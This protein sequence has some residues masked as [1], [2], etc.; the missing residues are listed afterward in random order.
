MGQAV[1]LQCKCCGHEFHQRRGGGFNHVVWWCRTCDAERL[2]PRH[3]PE[4]APA[5]TTPEAM[6]SYLAEGAAG[7]PL[8]G[9]DFTAEEQRLLRQLAGRCICGGVLQH[10]VEARRPR[11]CPV[12]GADTEEDPLDCIRFD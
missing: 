1:R 10:D 7:W 3:A 12:C 8:S 6:R 9:R 11:H 2:L 4:D 5:L